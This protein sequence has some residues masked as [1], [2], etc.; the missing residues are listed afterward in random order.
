MNEKK[1][2]KTKNKNQKKRGKQEKER[3]IAYVYGH[4]DNIT[5]YTT[6]CIH[7]YIN[8]YIPALLPRR[9]Q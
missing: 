9:R 5:I 7:I 4:T 1:K 8:R 6:V 3:N 2:W